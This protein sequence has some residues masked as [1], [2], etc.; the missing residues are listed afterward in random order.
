MQHICR[1]YSGSTFIIHIDAFEQRKFSG[2]F[3]FPD[4]EKICIFENLMQ[5]LFQ[6]EQCLD[7]ANEPQAFTAM[8]SFLAKGRESEYQKEYMLSSAGKLA[9]FSV[10][11]M[12]RRNASWQGTVTWMEEG[13]KRNFRSVLEL[14]F[15]INNALS[16]KESVVFSGI[17]CKET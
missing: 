4:Q 2:R 15:L 7:A 11:I 3:C 13:E 1:K 17:H 5:L 6:M 16:S 14:L 12:F 9:S 10:Q 8:R